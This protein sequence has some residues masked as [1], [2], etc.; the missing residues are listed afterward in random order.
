M[1]LRSEIEQ[2]DQDTISNIE[3]EKW[4]PVR[5]KSYEIK[6]Q[7]QDIVLS[8]E[9]GIDIQQQD[10]VRRSSMGIKEGDPNNDIEPY[11]QE[12]EAN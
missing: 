10:W 9:T 1:R 8:N 12:T 5:R 11:N 3:I 4:D 7:D 6:Q 2:R